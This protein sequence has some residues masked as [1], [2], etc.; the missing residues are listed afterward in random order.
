MSKLYVGVIFF[1]MLMASGQ[2]AA[3]QIINTEDV[4]YVN[5]TS[6]GNTVGETG[7]L[8]DD[9]RYKEF[10]PSNPVTPYIDGWWTSEGTFFYGGTARRASRYGSGDNT[11]AH[12][13]F[14]C[15]VQ[16]SGYYLVYHQMYP[17]GNQTTDAYVTFTRFG[18]NAPADS[19]RYNMQF[20]N[21]PEGRGSWYPLGAIQLYAGDSSL[22]VDIGLDSVG[23]NTLIADAVAL[24]KS[25]QAGPDLEFGPRRFTRVIV[26]PN[27]QDT[28]LNDNFYRDRAPL[29]FIPTTF[30]GESFTTRKLT[31]YNLGQT[32][33]TVTGLETY[34]TRFS[35]TTSVPF[36]IE[37]GGKKD[38]IIKFDP[39]GEEITVDSLTVISDDPLEPSATIGL[40]GE[41]INYNIIMNA[42]LDGSEP[43]FN[44]IGATFETIG[45]NWLGSTA[46]PFTY[47]IAEGNKRSV[48][49]I[50]A[51][52]TG[53]AAIYRFALPE[54]LFGNY[55]IEYGG[56]YSGNAAVNAT[57]EVVTP[58][59]SDTQKVVSFNENLE[60]GGPMWS[61]IGGNK[62]F[63]LNGGG[64][65]VIKFT[66]PGAPNLR[67]DLL[68]VRL[69]PLAPDISTTLD[70]ARVLNFGSVSI[71]DSIRLS[72]YNYQK[73]FVIGSNGETPLIIDSI[74]I[75]GDDAISIDNLPPFP[76]TLPA[77]DGQYNLMLS[78]LPN[79]IKFHSDTLRI[80][81]NDPQDSIISL[82]IIGQGVG[83]GIVVDDTDP[84]TYIYPEAI[85]WTGEPDP[86]NLDKWYRVAGSGSNQ[87]RMFTYI[88]NPAEENLKSVEWFPAFPF[89]PGSSENTADTFDVYIQASAGSMNSS[90]AAKYLVKH[91][92]GVDTFI[93]NQNSIDFG[94]NMDYNGRFYLGQFTFLRGGQDSY[95]SG[96]VFGSVQLINDT[97]LVN[98]FFKDSVSNIARDSGYV[99]RADAIVIQQASNVVGVFDPQIKPESYS[100]SQNYPNPFNPTTQIN[101]SLPKQS[102]VELKIYDILGREVASLFKGEQQAGRYTLE[103]NGNNNFGSKVASGIYIYRIVAGKFIQSKK[104]MLLK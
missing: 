63:E 62:V 35:T 32:A 71:Y 24:L 6:D 45:A 95:G 22:T 65:T 47:P 90:P 101:Y 1:L 78:F 82:R 61:R 2:I 85:E 46:S 52:Q 83:T 17:T 28:T 72:E 33:L 16:K 34:T 29:Q 27:T 13:K 57:V 84:T 93:V 8:M 75:S 30:R 59:I 41:G 70:P 68:R 40:S 5:N 12:A 14:F 53:C 3:Q 89:K 77:I 81:S 42:S 54:Q 38:V 88:Y 20:N 21:T 39:K 19:F 94:G 50:G 103:W 102:I 26:D 60:F 80:V 74:Y 44:I 25:H 76:L 96:T 55:Y 7:T 58:F 67:A 97:S 104:M 48:V 49:N 91:Y 66:N 37:P 79:F 10:P 92:Y 69:I 99:L 56:P 11:G 73:S 31:L 36:S 18:E 15:T 4:I 43:H 23:G 64:E 9:P 51:D 98:D 87:T 86:L 100:L